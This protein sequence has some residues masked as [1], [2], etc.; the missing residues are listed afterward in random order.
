[1]QVIPVGKSL[2]LP[3]ALLQE[4]FVN[5]PN[6]VEPLTSELLPVFVRL[7]SFFLKKKKKPS[8]YRNDYIYNK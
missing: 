3:N 5:S 6:Q 1:M 8:F 4:G 7:T 2:R